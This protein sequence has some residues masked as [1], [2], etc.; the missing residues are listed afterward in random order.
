M[1]AKYLAV[2]AFA[3][4]VIT[5]CDY[6][7]ADI[8]ALADAPVQTALCMVQTNDYNKIA[9]SC[10]KGEKIVFTPTRFGNEQLPVIFAAVNCDHRYSIALTKGAVSCIYK[11]IEP[12][13]MNL[14][15]PE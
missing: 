1:K 5:G 8:A 11:P 12:E 6:S 13:K 9:E 7:K 15:H 3:S 4:L 2:T 14:V 10:V